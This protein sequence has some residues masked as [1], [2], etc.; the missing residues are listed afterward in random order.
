MEA[1]IVVSLQ[2]PDGDIFC[3]CVVG[4]SGGQQ[5]KPIKSTLFQNEVKEHFKNWVDS[6]LPQRS[7]CSDLQYDGEGLPIF[8]HIRLDGARGNQVKKF[9]VQFF[10]ELWCCQFHDGTKY[11]FVVPLKYL[12]ELGTGGAFLMAE[13]L[14]KFNPSFHFSE[15]KSSRIEDPVD[16]ATTTTLTQAPSSEPRMSRVKDSVDEAAVAALPTPSPSSETGMVR[17]DVTVAKAAATTAS[18]T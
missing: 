1:F 9:L 17:V 16:T 18:F 15:H 12:E 7:L 14:K 8:P 3:K 6:I 4:G 10:E 2:T 13:Y 11:P 5:Y